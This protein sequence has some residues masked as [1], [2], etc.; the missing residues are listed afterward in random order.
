MQPGKIMMESLSLNCEKRS[1]EEDIEDLEPPFVERD[2]FESSTIAADLE[3]IFY[4]AK[5]IYGTS[6]DNAALYHALEV[7]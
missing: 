7:H 2:V 1:E 5:K 6:S 4:A 3:S